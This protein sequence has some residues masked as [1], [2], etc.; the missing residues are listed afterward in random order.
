MTARHD[1]V[2]AVAPG[3][4]TGI[5][6]IVDQPDWHARQLSAAFQARDIASRY[7]R[8][9]DCGFDLERPGG[10]ILP[11]F[12]AGLPKAAFVRCVPG[13]S[14]EEVTLCLSVLHAIQR[15]G[16]PVWNDAKAI[17]R[18]VD[19]AMTT[20]LLQRAGVPTPPTWVCRSPEAAR[21]IAERELASDSP[22]VL[23]PLFGSQGR[24]LRLIETLQDLPPPE[25]VSGVYYLQR[26][27]RSPGSGW[28]DWRVLVAAGRP[29][30]AMIRRGAKWVTNRHQGAA[31]EA[32]PLDDELGSLAV[33]AVHAVGAGYAGVDVIRDADGRHQVLEVNSMPSWSALQSVSTLDLTQGLVDAFLA[34]ILPPRSLARAAG[35]A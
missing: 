15:L 2:P 16:I 34:E 30:A 29:M 14:F 6:I 24:G 18:C 12:E 25:E 22:L 35:P 7:L 32:W 33:G 4:D 26:F 23:K 10:L 5:A 11:G 28:Q 20:F 31:C 21:A 13:G 9:R 8:L 3:P 1:P 27:V 19:K 17:E